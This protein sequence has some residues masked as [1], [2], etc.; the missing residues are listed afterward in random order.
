MAGQLA[1]LRS[2][3]LAL[4]E[5]SIPADGGGWSSSRPLTDGAVAEGLEPW[6]DALG[7]EL[8]LLEEAT[9]RL[10]GRVRDPAEAP[11]EARWTVAG[12]ESSCEPALPADAR[13]LSLSI[14]NLG[15]STLVSPQVIGTDGRDWSCLAGL[16]D[17]ALAGAVGERERSLAL[18]RWLVESRSHGSPATADLLL[19]DPVLLVNVYG[20][21]FCDDAAHVLAAL[22]GAAGLQ[23]RVWSLNGHVVPEVRM[24]GHW[25]LLDPDDEAYFLEADGL[26]IAGAETLARQPDLLSSPQLVPG[27]TSA[28]YRVEV[29]RPFFETEADNSHGPA[30]LPETFLELDY[31]LAPGDAIVFSSASAGRRHADSYYQRP[32]E[33]ANGKLL[34]RRHL[35]GASRATPVVLELPYVFV[36][37]RLLAASRDDG[38]PPAV[39][40]RAGDGAWLSPDWRRHADGWVLPLTDALRIASGRPTSRLA[41]RPLA[42]DA[43]LA[44][45]VEL[46]FQVAPRS[47]PVLTPGVSAVRWRSGSSEAR[48]EIVARF[49]QP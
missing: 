38:P 48:A 9:L 40:V 27:R 31:D 16:L 3:T 43:A 35:D 47:L 24:D 4:R 17:D 12:R 23:A 14:R 41:L 25:A 15:E 7:H 18:W 46:V 1:A 28:Y 45:D 20:Y 8:L 21:G 6:V 11:A 49:E 13:L 42:A 33:W 39:A 22:A 5:L 32:R 36:A 29:V 44:V 37:G 19:H 2:L 10:T 30:V 34:G 26:K